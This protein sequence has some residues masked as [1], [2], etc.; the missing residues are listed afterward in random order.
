MNLKK[1]ALVC[2]RTSPKRAT[3]TVIQKLLYLAALKGLTKASYEAHYY[4]PYSPE[5]ASTLQ[6]LSSSGLVEETTEVLQPFGDPWEVRRYQYSLSKEVEK[7]L[8]KVLNE[9]DKVEAKKLEE[10]IGT[11]EKRGS[12]NPKSLS[13]A[14]KV[15]YI[16][17]EMSHPLTDTQ[18]AKKAR[19]LGWNI[20]EEEIENSVVGLLTDLQLV[21]RQ[22]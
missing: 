14:T 1:A 15:L 18:I 10:L 9:E 8:D 13:V 22:R 16:L 3:R 19:E 17:H 2:V 5:V 12:L 21:T 6:D 20:T 11:C 4:G 7:A